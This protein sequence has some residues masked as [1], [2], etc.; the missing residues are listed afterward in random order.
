MPLEAAGLGLVVAALVLLEAPVELAV[1][2]RRDDADLVVLAA[3]VARGVDDGV[4]V[5]ARR[6]RLA[7][8]LAEPLH[9]LLLQVVGDVVLLAEEDHAAARDWGFHSVSGEHQSIVE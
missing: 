8:Q 6:R 7:R 1:L 4:D 3:A 5:Q 2:H 9:E